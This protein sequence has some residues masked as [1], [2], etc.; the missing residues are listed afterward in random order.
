MLF[1]LEVRLMEEVI[2]GDQIVPVVLYGKTA[3]GSPVPIQLDA[4]GKLVVS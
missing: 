1:G 2:H 4:D 3:D